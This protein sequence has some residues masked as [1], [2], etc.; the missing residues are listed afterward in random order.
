MNILYTS[1]STFL[2]NTIVLSAYITDFS[3]EH[4][5][6]VSSYRIRIP[7]RSFNN[8]TIIDSLMI[9]ILRTLQDVV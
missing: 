3:Q 1:I 7:I 4:F 6:P 5:I 8:G 9:H 2:S